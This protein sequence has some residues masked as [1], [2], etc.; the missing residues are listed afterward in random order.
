MD[1]EAVAARQ[2]RVMWVGGVWFAALFMPLFLVPWRW[3]P[4]GVVALLLLIAG[5]IAAWRGYLS[6]AG[7]DRHWR[8]LFLT[9]P[10]VLLVAGFALASWFPGRAF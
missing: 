10:A 4:S 3:S 6:T 7:L 9:V 5:A 1:F 8:H 2:I